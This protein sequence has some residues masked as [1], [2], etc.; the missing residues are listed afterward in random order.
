MKIGRGL[1]ALMVVI[2]ILA[3]GFTWRLSSSAGQYATFAQ[4]LT[5]K[6]VKMYG[7]FW[8]SHCNNQKKLFG[9]SWASVEYIECS[10]PD[11]AGQTSLCA[12]A[13]ITGY[14]TWEFAGGKRVSGE[15]SL[16]DLSAQSG[17]LLG[18]AL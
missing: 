7:A 13:G 9:S 2:I 14:P 11:G 17:C 16:A 6:G 3:I 10:T 15:M 4:C 5:E 18:G 1:A 8:C 12:A